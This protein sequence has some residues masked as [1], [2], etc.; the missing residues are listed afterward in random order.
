MT[1]AIYLIDVSNIAGYIRKKIWHSSF[2]CL[3]FKIGSKIY[4]IDLLQLPDFPNLSFEGEDLDNF[5]ANNQIW[6]KSF[7]LEDRIE[8]FEHN[9]SLFQKYHQNM[10]SSLAQHY[11][12]YTNPRLE[13]RT[14]LEYLLFLM[15]ALQFEIKLTAEEFISFNQ[16]LK[17]RNLELD[18]RP[19]SCNEFLTRS[20]VFWSSLEHKI[21]IPSNIPMD[22]DNLEFIKQA[23]LKLG[24]RGLTEISRSIDMLAGQNIEATDDQKIDALAEDDSSFNTIR[25]HL[26]L[27][28]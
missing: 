17:L 12:I 7:L 8:L 3:G 4:P 18:F 15:Y 2:S 10:T 20:N 22:T 25:K 14:E 6:I 23:H 16:R 1:I 26:G 9:W 13:V 11:Y 21:L 5:P 27:I 28:D 24:H 19:F